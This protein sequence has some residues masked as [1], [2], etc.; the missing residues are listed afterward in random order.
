MMSYDS[1]GMPGSKAEESPVSGESHFSGSWKDAI[2]NL[3]A[4]RIGI[5]RIESQDAIEVA[6]RKMILLSVALFSLF[7][8]WGLLTAGLI[9]VISEHFNCPWY[10]AAFSVGGVYLLISL[11][12]LVIIK[13][14]K[15]TESFPITRA[16]FEKDRKWLNQ[17]NNRS[18]S[19]S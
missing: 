7:A 13:K 2:P 14:A 11:V 10:F 8:T 4:S 3:I 1:S 9:G 15:R 19:Q 18:N 17:L 5:I 12:M 16:E 6:V